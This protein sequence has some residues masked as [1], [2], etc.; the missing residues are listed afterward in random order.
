MLEFQ[1]FSTR[2]TIPSLT[3]RMK[4][5]VPKLQVCWKA[6]YTLTTLLRDGVTWNGAL[7]RLH[8]NMERRGRKADRTPEREEN[9]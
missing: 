7:V 8:K 9:S 6:M 4:P 5:K 3:I 2:N 1:P